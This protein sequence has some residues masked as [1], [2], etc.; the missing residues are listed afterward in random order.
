MNIYSGKNTGRQNQSERHKHKVNNMWFQVIIHMV[1][2]AGAGQ[3]ARARMLGRTR[4]NQAPVTLGTGVRVN[5][6]C[7][8]PGS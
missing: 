3:A 2:C 1:S 5:S 4:D 8:G 6:M 7:W